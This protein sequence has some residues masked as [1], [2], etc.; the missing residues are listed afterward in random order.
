LIASLEQQAVEVE[1]FAD[2]LCERSTFSVELAH[3]IVCH[4][5]R[6]LSSKLICLVQR[7]KN[8]SSVGS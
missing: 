6:Y 1:N 7:R 3:A 5:D 2:Q 8:A 4:I